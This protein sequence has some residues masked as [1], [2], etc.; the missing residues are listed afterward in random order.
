MAPNQTGIM[1]SL[2]ANQ[3]GSGAGM[4]GTFNSSAQ[5]LSIGIFFTLMILGLA[6]SLPGALYHGLHAQG[7]P[8]AVATRASHLPPVGSLF[9]AFLGYNPVQVLLGPGGRWAHLPHATGLLP[10]QSQ[11]F[12]HLIAQ[13]FHKGLPRPSPFAPPCVCSVPWPRCSGVAS[14]TTRTT[15]VVGEEMPAEGVEHGLGPRG[16]CRDRTPAGGLTMAV[17]TSAAASRRDGS[18]PGRGR[19]GGDPDQRRRHP[20]RR[21]GPHPALLR[22]ARPA[23][24]VALHAGW[25]ASLHARRPGTPRSASS[26]CARCSG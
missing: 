14:I 22:G 18:I 4:A 10:D 20:G 16:H 3:R 6:A 17:S 1:N 12:P 5:V 2:P 8:T 9:A 11:F 15:R 24:P 26:S 19:R 13:P 25:R 7:V 21:V 23:Q